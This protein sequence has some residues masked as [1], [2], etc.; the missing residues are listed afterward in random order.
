MFALCILKLVFPSFSFVLFFKK[1]KY[2]SKEK[3]EF[4]TWFE[5]CNYLKFL[6]NHT[7]AINRLQLFEQFKCSINKLFLDR[8][9]SNKATSRL[10]KTSSGSLYTA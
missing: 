9:M 2:K 8:V 6:P 1:E 3:I 4:K 10:A 5:N 7:F